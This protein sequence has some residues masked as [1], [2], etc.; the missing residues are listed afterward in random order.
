[1]KT[2]PKI[3]LI[4]ANER[5]G[6][7]RSIDLEALLSKFSRAKNVSCCEVLTGG[8]AGDSR[9]GISGK[10]REG[11][12]NRILWVGRFSPEQRKCQEADL[13]AAGLNPYLQE[14]CDLGEQGIYPEE[15]LRE[16]RQQKATVLIQMALARARLLE[17][18]EPLCIPGTNALLLVGGGIAGLHAASALAEAGKQVYLIERESG[19]GGKVARLGRLYPRIC[20]PHC[21]LDFILQKI[22]ATARVELHTLA[23]VAEIQGGPGNFVV[24]VRK[25]PRYVDETRCNAC[26]ECLKVCPVVLPDETHPR[27]SLRQ[28]PREAE[29]AAAP[30]R[31]ISPAGPLNYPTAYVIERSF[32]PPHCRD[33]ADAC[34][35]AAV[36]LEQLPSEVSFRVGAL[37]LTTGWDPYPLAKI[38]EYG[39]G[40][41][42]QVI[43]SLEMEQRAASLADIREIGFIQC[44]GSRDERHL[45]YCSAVCCSA[46]LKQVLALK[47]K[48]PAVRCY[49]FYQDIRTPG[50]GEEL[51]QRVKALEGVLF[52]RSNPAVV[53]PREDGRLGVRVEDTFSGKELELSL[54][55]LVLAGGMIPSA[56]GDEIAAALKLPRNAHGFFESHLPCHG[57][58]SQRPGIRTGGA[59]RGPMGIDRAIE[60]AQQA[61]LDVLPLLGETI[62]IAPTVPV[63]NPAKCDKCKRCMEE[64]PFD[65]FSFDPEGY[66]R[67][68]WGKC[69]QC[70]GCMGACP[71]LAISRRHATIEQLSAQVRACKPAFLAREEPAVL[72]FLCANDAYPAARAAAEARLSIPANVFFLTVPCAGAVNNALIADAL[73]FGIDGVLIAG[74]KDGQC[75]YVR[76][77]QLIK[78]R[79]DDLQAKLQSMIMEP[80]RVRLANLEIRDARTYVELIRE[81][82]EELKRMGPNPFRT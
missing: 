61:A 54:D 74:C 17:P 10:F 31:A 68:D 80:G 9:E 53:R 6:L 79:S 35:N 39:Y 50:L 30:R 33:C 49:I 8:W 24:R 73:A 75:H 60:T 46:T 42:P 25:E 62:Q 18:L 52:I 5:D 36:A 1:M 71:L 82:I 3:A 48:N 45:N 38:E 34:P 28:A 40:Q 66:P 64:C 29:G 76:G 57:E 23:R 12:F 43:T 4:F 78:T 56:G 7:S 2:P 15:G 72:A 47:E 16:L 51:Y 44:V 11:R 26:G 55:L 37:L 77:N 69:R 14:W 65:S 67:V 27:P 19:V 70:G 59:S 81:Y 13:E 32:C 63:L 22:R 41:H 58:E 20:D 21:G